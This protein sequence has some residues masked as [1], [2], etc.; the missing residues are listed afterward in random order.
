MLLL[1]FTR[2]KNQT[3]HLPKSKPGGFSLIHGASG[4]PVLLFAGLPKPGASVIFCY[5]HG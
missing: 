3:F 5:E 2:R 4:L 1:N